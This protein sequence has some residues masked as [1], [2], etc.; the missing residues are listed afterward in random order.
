MEVFRTISIGGKYY[1]YLAQ[2]ESKASSELRMA[3]IF[4]QKYMNNSKI[5]NIQIADTY[6]FNSHEIN[7]LTSLKYKSSLFLVTINSIFVFSA[8]QVEI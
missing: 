1:E 4:I 6:L 3:H 8:S 7:F 2:S 5:L